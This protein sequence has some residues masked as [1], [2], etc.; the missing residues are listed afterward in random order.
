M[1]TPK[2]L[3]GHVALVTG[4]SSGIG[5][6][7]ALMLAAEGCDVALVARSADA[8]NAVANQCRARTV[9][10][11][12]IPCDVGDSAALAAAV[13]HARA[14]LGPINV[15][16]NAAGVHRFASSHDAD[17]R[18]WDAMIDIN[19]R[20]TMHAT[21][22]S[23]PDIAAGARAGLRGAVIV[24]SSLGGKFAA[25][26]NAAYSASKFALTGFAGSVFE[27]ARD[28]GVKVCALYPGWTN[29]GMLA[30]WLDPALAIQ[31][32]DIAAL[33]R[34][35]VLFPANACPTE[36]VIQPQSGRAA[37]LFDS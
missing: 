9:R 37:R 20:A 12:P 32:E 13:A 11:E 18:Q 1:T 31:P 19:L 23:L 26:T 3:A 35:V 27:D 30:D 2:T 22:L 17:L 24:I 25:P 14:T 6:A 15:L 21:R 33:I 5:R 7:T 34:T 28:D 29:T 4:A 16:V 8:L 10:A 36:I